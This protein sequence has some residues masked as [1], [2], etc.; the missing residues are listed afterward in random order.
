[1]ATGDTLKATKAKV[2]GAIA[3]VAGFLLPGVTYLL[4]VD[5]DGITGTE[6]RHAALLAVAAAAG[7]GA[8]VGGAVYAVENRRKSPAEL[9]G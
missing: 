5:Q 6:W 9:A 7:A 8:A 1:M 3:A 2:G 4:T